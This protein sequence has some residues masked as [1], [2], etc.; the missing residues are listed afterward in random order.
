MSLLL[1][2]LAGLLGISSRSLHVFRRRSRLDE[3][4]AEERSLPAS[5]SSS[6]G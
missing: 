4:P 5:E 1:D 3:H 2:V 6:R